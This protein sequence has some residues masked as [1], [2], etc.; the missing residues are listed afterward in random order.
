MKKPLISVITISL[1]A[2]K[3]IEQT[4]Q[5]V[6]NQTYKNIEHIIIDGGSTDKTVQIINKYR[7]RIDHFISEKDEGI[8]DAMNKGVALAKG[9]Y[10]IFIHAD[11]YFKNDSSLEDALEYL[12]GTVDI[13]ACDIQYGKDL[14]VIKPR[15]F[16]FWFNFKTGVLHQGVI[17]RKSLIRELN[18]FDKIFKITMDFDFFLRSYRLH[19]KLVKAPVILSVMRNTGI[20]SRQDWASLKGRFDEEKKVHEKNCP[21]RYMMFLYNIYWPLYLPYRF[22]LNI[23]RELHNRNL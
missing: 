11:D 17:C 1:N 12:D 2:E 4:I 10:V 22:L 19:A 8:A 18:G 14:K 13:L 9:D 16:N 21:S 23:I 20:S 7:D 15:G 3:Y 5:S 6:L